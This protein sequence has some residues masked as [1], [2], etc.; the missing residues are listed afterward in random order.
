[1][2]ARLQIDVQ[3]YVRLINE[4]QCF[5]YRDFEVSLFSIWRH[6]TMSDNVIVGQSISAGNDSLRG[7]YRLDFEIR[8]YKISDACDDEW[9]GK[10]V[11]TVQTA[12]M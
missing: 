11:I 4:L 9:N 6:V 12:A 7:F 5:Q 1:M 3:F 8:I 10:K 2:Q